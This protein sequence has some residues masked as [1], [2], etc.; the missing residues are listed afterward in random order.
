[1]Y[2]KILFE[3]YKIFKTPQE[4]CLKP[5]TI[6]FGKNNSGKS[7]IL[8][9]PQLISNSFN[10]NGVEVVD[11]D[12]RQKELFS[13]YKDLIYGRANRAIQISL[14]NDADQLSYSFFIDDTKDVKSHLE[15]WCLSENNVLIYQWTDDKFDDT[16]NLFSGIVPLKAPENIK[17]KVTSL[18]YFIDYIGNIRH[19]VERDMRI[20]TLSEYS[21]WSGEKGYDYLLK[22]S[23]TTSRDL[24]EKVSKWYERTFPGWK[25]DVDASTQP[26]YHVILDN[27]ELSINIADAGFGIRQSLPIVIRANRSC[28]RPTL[29]ILEE[30]EAHLHPAAHGNLGELLVDSILEDVNKS[31]LVETHSFNFILRIR[32]LIAQ[33]KITPDKVALYYVDYNAEDKSSNLQNVLIDEEGNVDSWPQGVFEETYDEVVNIRKNQRSNGDSD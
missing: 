24:I 22:D 15:T 9:L 11:R 31:Y 25:L 18:D 26:V 13:E 16:S 30:P 14:S 12:F 23:L 5:I 8:T 17:Q 20:G 19:I 3:R 10:A 27:G 32:A 28:V 1:M 29:I 6:L 21:G 4:L 33:R 7:S 2:K